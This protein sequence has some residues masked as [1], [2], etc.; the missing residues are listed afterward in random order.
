MLTSSYQLRFAA[1]NDTPTIGAATWRTS[2]YVTISDAPHFLELDWQAATAPGANN[3]MLNFWIDGVQRPSLIN[4]DNESRRIDI[5]RL[6]PIGGL[7]T[8]TRG[9]YYFD[10]FES[11]RR[12]YI[13]PV[14]GS[15][16]AAELTTTDE[17]LTTT[18]AT[19]LATSALVA[20]EATT[21]TA[22]VAGLGVE[23]IFPA[24]SDSGAITAQ[25]YITDTQS[26]PAGYTLLGD[27]LAV[28]SSALVTQPV[29]MTIAYGIAATGTLTTTVSLQQ[30]NASAEQWE[31]LPAQVN[32]DIQ[33]IT[34]AINVPATLALWQP[35]T[36]TLPVESVEENG[37]TEETAAPAQ[38]SI[39]LPL[40][41]K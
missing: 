37:E 7:D 30:W 35:E 8:G 10:A 3:G 12:T 36:E 41:Q 39:Y 23:A 11:R 31:V 26:L 1:L 20:T 5:A 13:G 22:D 33:T 24:I 32:H 29:T 21:L 6:G 40:V 25:L 4:L 18:V 16:L 2:S 14:G 27:M 34:A 9:S 17:T 15:A 28:Q 19:V 38:F